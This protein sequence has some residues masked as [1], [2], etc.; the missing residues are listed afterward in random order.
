MWQVLPEE[1]TLQEV[2]DKEIQTWLQAFPEK[3]EMAIPTQKKGS[4]KPQKIKPLLHLQSEMTFCQKLS[5][6]KKMSES[7]NPSYWE[8]NRNFSWKWWYWILILCWWRTIWTNSLWHS[9][10]PNYQWNWV[11]LRVWRYFPYITII[12]GTK[13]R[14]IFKSNSLSTLPRKDPHI[15]VCQ[16]Y[17]CY[18]SHWHRRHRSKLFNS[19]HQ[20]SS[21]RIL[22]SLHPILQFCVRRYFLHQCHN[23][24]CNNPVFPTVLHNCKDFRI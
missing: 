13:P 2:L 7:S 3:E 15:E 1:E 5:S 10:L 16:T 4:H 9:L 22:D 24:S 12:P 6:S 8:W 14:H 18:C 20:N 19:R 11:R 21:W 23:H 17:H